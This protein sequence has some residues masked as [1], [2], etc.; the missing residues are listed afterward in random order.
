VA[1]QI[2]RQLAEGQEVRISSGT[3]GWQTAAYVCAALFGLQ[4]L[5]LLLGLGISLIGR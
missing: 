3:S 4:F 5:L 1:A 2:V